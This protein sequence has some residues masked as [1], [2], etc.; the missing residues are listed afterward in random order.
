MKKLFRSPLGLFILCAALIALGVGGWKRYAPSANKNTKPANVIQVVSAA[1]MQADVLVKLTSSGTVAALQSVDVR[2]Q[3][4]AMVKMVHV[5]EGQ[6]VRKGDR[7]FTL[8]TR[9]EDA[10]LKKAEA[11]V[12]K[13]KADLANAERNLERVKALLKLEYVAQSEF[14]TAQNLVDGLR[15]QLAIDL[16]A[17]ETSRVARSF[18]EITAPIS[19]RTGV[20]SVYPGNLVQPAATTALV[21]IA[22]L[23]PINISFTL[24]ERE[25]AGLQ[26]AL[27][28]GEVPVYAKL[29]VAEQNTLTGYLSFID[30]NVDTSSGTIH[31]KAVFSNADHRLWPGMFVSVEIAPRSLTNVLTVP[32][33]AVQTGPEKK[34]LYVIGKDNKVASAPINVVLIQD[35]LAVVEGVAAGERVVVEG[36]HNLKPNSVVI[37]AEK[38]TP[39]TKLTQTKN[40]PKSGANPNS[41]TQP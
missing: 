22:Q 24:P 17:V 18:D 6:F 16:A 31:L 25:L 33:Q 2:P 8:D 15:S 23:D 10:N 21:S 34:F 20:I 29:D 28:K 13:D 27:G 26:Q 4:S 41:A 30:N 1:V 35:S 38:K 32:A 3:I 39:D 7:L 36:A 37:A 9:T 5:K 40:T 14:D 12:A 11:Q 19:G